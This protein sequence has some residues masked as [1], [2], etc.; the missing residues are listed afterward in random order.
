MKYA[1]VKADC[2]NLD[3][4]SFS[5]TFDHFPCYNNVD[6]PWFSHS[7]LNTSKERQQLLQEQE[8]SLQ[9]SIKIDR[10]KEEEKRQFV[11]Q[12]DEERERRGGNCM[13]GSHKRILMFKSTC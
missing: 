10:C 11:I 9:Q 13:I 7:I 3:E 4:T 1:N 5:S 8:E 6:F 2:F 12:Q